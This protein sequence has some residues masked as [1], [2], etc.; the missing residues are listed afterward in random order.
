M[1]DFH[2]SEPYPFELLGSFAGVMHADEAEKLRLYGDPTFRDAFKVDSSPE[3][4]NVDAGWPGRDRDLPLRP[5]SIDRGATDS[6]S[7]PRERGV[8]PVDLALDLGSASDLAARFRF[9]FLNHDRVR[10][11]R[12]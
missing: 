1:F 6:P 12:S 11:T 7:L 4:K 3:A 8:H 10:G 9:A 2:F 5:R